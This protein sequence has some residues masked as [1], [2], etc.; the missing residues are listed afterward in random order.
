MVVTRDLV[1]IMPP[2]LVP[3]GS[4]PFQ[5]RGFFLQSREFKPI[6]EQVEKKKLYFPISQFLL[7]NKIEIEN[8]F[9]LVNKAQKKKKG[10]VRKKNN[11]EQS[12]VRG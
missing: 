8:P 11:K 12:T 7:V 2:Q 3:Q 4:E 6:T 1:Q 9:L 5:S 10:L